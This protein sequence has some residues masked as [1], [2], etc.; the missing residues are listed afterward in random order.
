MK[1]FMKRQPWWGDL[2][3]ALVFLTIAAGGALLVLKSIP[4]TL[5]TAP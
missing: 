2:K 5:A 3:V 4:S 1:D